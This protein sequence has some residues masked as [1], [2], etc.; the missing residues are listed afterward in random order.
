M[1]TVTVS[2]GMGEAAKSV[3]ISV[4]DALKGADAG[5]TRY[6]APEDVHKLDALPR[7]GL[8]E[9]IADANLATWRAHGEVLA[10]LLVD[11][12]LPM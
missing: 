3:R 12:G 1:G 9:R 10:R 2:V 11:V 5:Q 8:S 4:L 6:V 7:K